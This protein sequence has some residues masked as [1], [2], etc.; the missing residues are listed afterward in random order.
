MAALLSDLRLAVRGLRA[1]PWTAAIAV[2]TLALGTGLTTAVY[3]VA[4]GILLRPQPYERADRL[5]LINPDGSL[6]IRRVDIDEWIARLRAAKDVAAYTRG[7]RFTVRGA[8]EPRVAETSIVSDRFFQVLGL[9]M[10]QGQPIVPGGPVTDIV[11]SDRLRR[12]LGSDGR[13]LLGRTL[14]IGDRA[15]VVAGVAPPS[16]GLPTDEVDIWLRL[17]AVPGIAVFGRADVRS[18]RL[19]ARLRDGATLAQL[20]GDVQRV[21][22]D[23]DR[24]QGRK[25]DPDEPRASAVP[26]GEELTAPLRP[27]L[28]AFVVAAVLVLAIAC[29]NV[30]VL[31]VART[32]ARRRELAVRLALGAGRWRLVRGTL[33]ESTVV[34]AAGAA[35]GVALAVP[36]ARRSSRGPARRPARDDACAPR[37]WRSRSPCRSSSSS[38]PGCS[39]ARCRACCPPTPAFRRGAH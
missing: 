13:P 15:F 39:R 28:A 6:S 30:A 10:E 7:E 31:L 27:V 2:L 16:L 22:A 19:V 11:V 1:T 14:T 37:S 12:E 8:G 36:T 35:L 24:E 20:T 23:L 38:A 5:A 34:A 4:Y 18:Y 9:A 26:V 33:A 21:N 29:A 32:L 25:P 3:A 17:D